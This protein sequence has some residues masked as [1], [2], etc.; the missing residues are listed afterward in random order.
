[1]VT[2]IHTTST[3]PDIPIGPIIGVFVGISLCI[4][5]GFLLYYFFTMY[6]FYISKPRSRPAFLFTMTAEER[7]C[8]TI[9]C[10][11][12]NTG[13]I[14]CC[15]PSLKKTVEHTNLYQDGSNN[16]NVTHTGSNFEYMLHEHMIHDAITHEH[17]THDD[18][19]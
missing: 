15:C 19:L 3:N 6:C 14:V 16:L 4:P 17:M 5:L 11:N 2:P 10:V 8:G 7:D 9:C 12:I 13:L 1:M 18:S